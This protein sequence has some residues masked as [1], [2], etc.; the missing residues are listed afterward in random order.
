MEVEGDRN[1]G[2]VGYIQTVVWVWVEEEIGVERRG[3][4]G[5]WGERGERE[6]RCMMLEGRKKGEV[7]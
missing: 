4:V 2:W 5:D 7:G 6:G 1:A 3:G